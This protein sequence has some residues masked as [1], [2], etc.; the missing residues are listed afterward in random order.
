MII[1][2]TI[3]KYRTEQK[4]TQEEMAI[5][6]YVTPQA[7]SRWETGISYPDIVMIPKIC[8]YLNVSADK[9]LGCERETV[10]N[11]IV[12]TPEP[13]DVLTQSQIDSM[14]DYVPSKK[15]SNK[16]VLIVDDSDFMRIMLKDILSSEGYFVIEAC[17]GMECLTILQTKK[18][19]ICILD[20]N[21]PVM[22]GIQTLKVIKEKYP[23]LKV[24]ML[25]IQST[26]ETVKK[27]LSLGATGFVAKPFEANNILE[28]II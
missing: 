27:V 21:M 19:D 13:Q 23:T 25:S 20:I 18:V 8:K 22:N 12:F 24:I 5:A 10:E 14:F 1:G 4:I 3:K 9:L 28:R 6:L 11:K 26:E 7:I 17:N 2:E 15:E 16:T